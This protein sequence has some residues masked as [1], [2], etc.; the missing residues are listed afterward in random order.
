MNKLHLSVGNLPENTEIYLDGK[1]F[2]PKRVKNHHPVIEYETENNSVELTV[3]KYSHLNTKFWL[4]QEIFFFI[5]S[6]FGILDKRFG[7]YYYQY[8]C[9]IIFGVQNETKATIKFKSPISAKPVLKCSSDNEI[10]E[11]ENI[12]SKNKNKNKKKSILNLS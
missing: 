11:I 2:I 6:I 7:R 8:N 12:Y 4:L 3:K 1:P 9:K 5:I 10:N